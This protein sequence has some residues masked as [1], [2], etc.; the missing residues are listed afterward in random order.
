MEFLG[1]GP[2]ELLVIFVLVLII[3]SP[4]DLAQAGRTMG[5]WLNRLNRSETW[6][7][8]REVSSEMQNL[9]GRLAREAQLEE[10]KELQKG[11][12]VDSGPPYPELGPVPPMPAASEA[13]PPEKTEPA[14][15]SAPPPPH[16]DIPDSRNPSDPDAAVEKSQ[17]GTGQ[18]PPG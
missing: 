6:R 8:M 2:L 18:D 11:I 12:P 13:A 1:I 14:A 17:T 5:R 3:F 16:A 7:S 9:P 15:K 10:L 4:K